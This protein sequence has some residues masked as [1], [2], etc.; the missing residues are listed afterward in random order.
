MAQDIDFMIKKTILLVA[1]FVGLAGCTE[2]VSQFQL[3]R[4]VSALNSY[5][6]A[7]VSIQGEG[8]DITTQYG[9]RKTAEV[10]H[11]NIVSAIL[12][13]GLFTTLNE[14]HDGSSQLE[15]VIL[16]TE[17]RYVSGPKRS[18]AWFFANDAILGGLIQLKD[19]DSGK[20]LGEMSFFEKSGD[21]KAMLSDYTGKQINKITD[22]T[23]ALLA[24]I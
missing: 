3:T 23:L 6:H 15:V 4:P 16:I 19:K 9:F 14:D 11:K 1:L 2:Q 18:L 24:T 10:M 5:K 22:L 7:I 20:I 13:T 12:P 17:F 21:Q 8:L